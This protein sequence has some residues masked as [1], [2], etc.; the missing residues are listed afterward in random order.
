[1]KRLIAASA[2]ALAACVSTPATTV[3]TTDT[4][5]S[6][7]IEGAPSGSLL[8]VDGLTMGDANAY[9]GRPA[10]LR[11]EP[12]THVVEVQDSAGRVMY[13]QTVFVESETKTIQVH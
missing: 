3:R 7:A 11:V 8:L 5:P 4:R 13:R 6:L 2:L 9:N 12:G 1:M 10:V